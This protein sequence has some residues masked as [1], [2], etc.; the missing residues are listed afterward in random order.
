MEPTSLNMLMQT[1]CVVADLN[2]LTITIPPSWI[3][4]GEDRLS[5]TTLVRL[6][7]CCREYHWQTDIL[8][9]INSNISLD[10]ICKSIY[11]E[12]ISPILVDSVISI[13]YLITDIRRK[14][15][16]LR[17]EVRNTENQTLCAKFDLVSIFY[18]PVT[19]KS[20]VP[21]PSVF[22]FLSARCAQGGE[23]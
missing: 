19:R 11:G 5:Y 4:E 20:I 7:E 17:F 13:T 2:G 9:K 14:G 18:D 8:P 12:F 6:I 22:D 15:Y 21:P 23:Q 1:G 16:S 3:I 10:S